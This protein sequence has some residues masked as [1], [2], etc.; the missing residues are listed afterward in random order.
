MTAPVPPATDKKKS[1]LNKWLIDVVAGIVEDPRIQAVAKKLIRETI[2]EDVMPLVPV[3]AGA[4]ATAAMNAAIKK[5]PG[6]EDTV[7]TVVEVGHVIDETRN[8]LNALIPDVDFGI[9][10]LDRVLDSWRPR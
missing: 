7:E 4:A 1:A 10:A 2:K 9:D 5:F 6:I 3:V 8:G